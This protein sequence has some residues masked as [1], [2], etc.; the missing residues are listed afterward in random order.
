MIKIRRCSR[1]ASRIAVH[2]IEGAWLE[3]ERH[4]SS[5]STQEA[6]RLW[7]CAKEDHIDCI[8]GSLLHAL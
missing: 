3:N 6:N 4:Y 2:C 1:T 5:A 7:N 8:P